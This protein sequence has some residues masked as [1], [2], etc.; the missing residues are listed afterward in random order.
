MNYKVFK[1]MASTIRQGNSWK[2]LVQS[3]DTPGQ[4]VLHTTPGHLN[5]KEA[6]LAFRKHTIEEGQVYNHFRIQPSK[7]NVPSKYQDW[8]MMHM[9]DIRAKQGGT[10]EEVLDVLDKM[11]GD[12][13]CDGTWAANSSGS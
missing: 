4:V 13:S 7:D 9:A 6:S 11:E 1:A 12:A 3:T 8:R 2:A 5:T 10:K